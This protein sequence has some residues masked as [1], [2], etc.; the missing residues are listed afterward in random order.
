MNVCVFLL[1]HLAVAVGRERQFAGGILGG[2]AWYAPMLNLYTSCRL[3]HGGYQK[4]G[5]FF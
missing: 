4:V 3:I 1:A 2:L 5:A